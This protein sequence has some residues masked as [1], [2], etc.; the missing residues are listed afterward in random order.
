MT[1]DDK[2]PDTDDNDVL[3]TERERARGRGGATLDQG[4]PAVSAS[5]GKT[6][7]ILILFVGIAGFMFYSLFSGEKK[8]VEKEPVK[9]SVA[10]VD[11]KPILPVDTVIPPPPPPVQQIEQLP[12]PPMPNENPVQITEQLPD[13]NKAARFKSNMM[14]LNGGG[15]RLGDRGKPQA[16]EDMMGDDPNRSFARLT[17]RNSA[18]EQAKATRMG[19]LN[20]TIAQGKVVDAVLETAINTELPGTLRAIVSRDIYS[21]AGKTVLIPKGSR[22][23]GT[24]NTGIMR[25]QKR[26]MIV[27]TRLIRPDGIDLEIGS[28]GIDHLG[29]A[30]VEGIVDNKYMEIFS[31]AILSS[32]ITFGAAALAQAAVGDDKST[33]SR[34]SYNDGSYEN[35]GNPTSA[36][37]MDLVGNVGQTSRQMLED[38]VDVRPNITIDQGTIIK[39][40]VNRDLIFPNNVLQQVKFIK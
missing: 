26:V 36:A 25:G 7:I 5:S 18:A 3:D 28:D 15:A 33:V 38:L 14:L 40:F 22:L 19:D 23:I 2:L 34:R 24:Y 35:A 4:V 16:E 27:W 29:R 10:P 11:T 13:E 30:G 31:S 17:V 9:Q 21:E 32:A 6:A 39:V 8:K 1:P 37:A 12:P 20:I